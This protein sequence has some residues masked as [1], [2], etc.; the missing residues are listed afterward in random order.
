MIKG[1]KKARQVQDKQI[2]A[3]QGAVVELA[4]QINELK[5]R[6]EALEGNKAAGKPAKEKAQKKA[7]GPKK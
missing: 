7:A 5:A 4:S 1:T 6:V 2:M 3:L